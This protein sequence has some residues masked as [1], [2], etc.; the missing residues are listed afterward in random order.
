MTSCLFTT[1]CWL[2]KRA[3][4]TV[5][6]AGGQVLFGTLICEVQLPQTH[7]K[8]SLPTHIHTYL[9]SCFDN[10]NGRVPKHTSGTSHAPNT[11]RPDVADVLGVVPAL[12]VPLQ[13]GIYKEPD[14]LIG[15]LLQNSRGQALV[16]A[17]QSCRSRQQQNTVPL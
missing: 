16:S 17:S 2:A 6:M 3:A 13:V 11:E 8:I 12:E 9:H 5:K 7:F 14:G 10:I 1:S 4:Y 15:A